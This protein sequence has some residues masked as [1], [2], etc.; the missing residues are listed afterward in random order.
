MFQVLTAA[1][2]KTTVLWD[3]APC[4][5]VEIGQRLTASI[6]NAIVLIHTYFICMQIDMKHVLLDYRD[7]KACGTL[8][9]FGWV[10]DIDP[11]GGRRGKTQKLQ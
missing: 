9:S 4:S 3:A 7:L 10:D 2:L 8:Y 11:V 1:T 5:L 6:I